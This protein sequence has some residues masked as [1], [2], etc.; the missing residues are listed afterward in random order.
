MKTQYELLSLAIAISS[1]AHIQQL[2]KGGKSYILHPLRLMF[3]MP[4]DDPELMQI[5][6]LH[7]VLEDCK[8]FTL[9]HLRQRYGFSDRVLHALMLLTHQESET[10]EEYID[11]IATN[12]DATLVK[13][14]DLQDNSCITRLKGIT[15][16]DLKRMEKYHRAYTKL[17]G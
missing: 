3:S 9:Q 11:K 16:K 2:D 12:K 6:V 5:A 7:D 15:E 8:E 13:L 14:A 17:R 10:Y 4:Q 1:H